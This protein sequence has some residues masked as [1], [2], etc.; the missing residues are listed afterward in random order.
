MIMIMILSIGRPAYIVPGDVTEDE[1]KL[2]V[3]LRYPLLAAE[4]N[5]NKSLNTPVESFRLMK[6]CGVSFLLLL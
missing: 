5:V 2:A 6:D 4:P 1:L 3:E